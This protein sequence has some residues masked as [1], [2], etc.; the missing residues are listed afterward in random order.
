MDYV[1]L[2]PL[3]ESDIEY[4]IVHHY[5]GNATMKEEHDNA[6]SKGWT[7]FPYNST[8][9]KT[10]ER[11]EGRGLN[12]GAHAGDYN[13]KSWGVALQ[14]NYEIDT[15]TTLQYNAL[16][17]ELIY[18]QKRFPKAKIVGH[19][20]LMATL[21]PGENIDMI[22]VRQ[23]VFS[24]KI[25]SEIKDVNDISVYALG[26]VLKYYDKKVFTGDEKGNF[27]PKNSISREDFAV[28]LDRFEK[29]LRAD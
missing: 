29:Y 17:D 15:I 26:S 10:G 18:L 1:N 19:R 22:K 11:V 27:N 3:K 9:L 28:V 4:I 7:G 2:R 12:R 13:G 23:D 6:L 5:G 14:G 24:A 20:E 25:E 21:C 16:V 8:I